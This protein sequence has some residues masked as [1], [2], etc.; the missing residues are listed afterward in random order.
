MKNKIISKAQLFE[1]SLVVLVS[2]SIMVIQFLFYQRL[3][4]VLYAPSLQATLTIPIVMIG[5]CLGSVISRRIF[6]QNVFHYR[7]LLALVA[8]ILFSLFLISNIKLG[9]R[10]KEF[11]ILASMIIPPFI[12]FGIFFGKVY[13]REERLA[14]VFWYNG[15]GLVLGALLAGKIYK[16]FGDIH[17]FLFISILLFLPIFI[18]T[19]RQM[20]KFLFFCFVSVFLIVLFR[21]GLFRPIIRFTPD[22]TDFYNQIVSTR[23]SE[24]GRMDVLNLEGANHIFCN[25]GNPTSIARWNQTVSLENPSVIVRREKNR[26]LPYFLRDFGKILIIGSGGGSDVLDAVKSRCKDI[27]AV[28]INPLTIKI[29]KEDYK[30]YSGGIYHHP[31]VKVVNTEGRSFCEN[32]H[33]AYDLIQFGG[34]DANAPW[35]P[36]SPISLEGYLYTREAFQRYW[37]ILKPGGMILISRAISTNEPHKE[38]M[39][40]QAMRLFNTAQSALSAVLT[41]RDSILLFKDDAL[42]DPYHLK[43]HLLISKEG[44]TKQDVDMVTSRGFILIGTS[45]QPAGLLALQRRFRGEKNLALTYDDRPAY[46]Y[47]DYWRKDAYTLRLLLFLGISLIVLVINPFRSKGCGFSRIIILLLILLGISYITLEINLVEK[48][49]LLLG[50]PTVANRIGLATFLLFGGIG[51][52]WGVSVK[53]RDIWRF[54]LITFSIVLISF[55]ILK[56]ISRFLFLPYPI[57]VV[58]AL[59]LLSLTGFFS[60]IPFAAILSKLKNRHMAYALDGFGTVAGAVSTWFILLNFGFSA[61]FCVVAILYLT[62]MLLLL[63]FR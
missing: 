20:K 36:P 60:S 40:F 29:V 43:Y 27:T 45:E 42:T 19:R 47:F 55:F 32:T 48:I 58:A 44:L 9:F 16:Y 41:K 7:L 34:V 63:V 30:E 28:E 39:L 26:V 37:N 5:Y 8:S 1:D 15:I 3:V 13:S 53:Q 24:I 35:R 46:H 6:R 17:S 14:A 51:G 2:F 12:F 52:Y 22:A 18:E 11:L 33:H 10:L 31:F 62:V 56:D 59:L 50:N 54:S 57:K 21:I 25:G 61:S 4:L 49:C 23:Y 38:I